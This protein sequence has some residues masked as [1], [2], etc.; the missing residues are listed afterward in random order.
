MDTITPASKGPRQEALDGAAVPRGRRCY[1]A[2]EAAVDCFAEA[3]L[4]QRP[5]GFGENASSNV[6]K[7]GSS[8]FSRLHLVC[9]Q[10]NSR[11]RV[12]CGVLL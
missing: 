6:Q 8:L 5:T 11:G 1:E 3:A 12:E 4:V 10:A 7:V 2:A 9:F